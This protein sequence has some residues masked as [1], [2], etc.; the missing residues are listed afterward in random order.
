MSPISFSVSVA[1]VNWAFL[2]AK[3]MAWF[4]L[5]QSYMFCNLTLLFR[6]GKSFIFSQKILLKITQHELLQFQRTSRGRRRTVCDGSSG[7]RGS[8]GGLQQIKVETFDFIPQKQFGVGA[9][10]ESETSEG[11]ANH[12]CVGALRVIQHQL[13]HNLIELHFVCGW[14]MRHHC[15]VFTA[16]ILQKT[17]IQFEI[18]VQERKWESDSQYN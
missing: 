3:K 18:E 4:T 11:F 2:T 9:A 7:S 13:C 12:V 8:T 14:L 17:N 16:W 10:D 15:L 5:Q 1:S 6:F